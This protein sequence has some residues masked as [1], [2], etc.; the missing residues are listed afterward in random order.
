MVLQ[1]AVRRTVGEAG[2]LRVASV[3]QSQVFYTDNMSTFEEIP[4]NVLPKL[5]PYLRPA[6]DYDPPLSSW[7]QRQWDHNMICI[8][9]NPFIAFL[10]MHECKLTERRTF[11][12][13]SKVVLV[14]SSIKKINIKFVSD[15]LDD[16]DIQKGI[17]CIPYL[18]NKKTDYPWWV[19][20]V[21]MVTNRFLFVCKF[22]M[23]KN[24]KLAYPFENVKSKEYRFVWYIEKL[25]KL[26][27][28]TGF[29]NFCEGFGKLGHFSINRE[30]VKRYLIG[31][32]QSITVKF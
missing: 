13:T 6:I 5:V 20:Q 7:N 1:Y 27:G 28:Q 9:I 3:S 32:S 19:Q 15:W 31:H 11:R 30:A 22:S 10:Q 21:K 29:K 26:Q 4:D 2:M 25:S 17:D 8:C 12:C 18:R 24:P 14:K 23:K 16:R